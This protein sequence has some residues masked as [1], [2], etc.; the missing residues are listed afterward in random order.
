MPFML[1]EADALKAKLGGIQVN[2]SSGSREIPVYFRNPENELQ[3]MTFPSIVMEYGSVTKADDREH[4]GVTTLP[5]I[6][7][8]YGPGPVASIDTL[9]GV[10]VEFSGGQDGKDFDPSLSPFKVKDWPV[11][12][13]IDFTITIYSRFQTELM[14]IIAELAMV[15]RIPSRFGFLE[16]PQDGTTRTLDLMAGPEIVAERDAGNRRVF[17]AVYSVRVTSELNLFGVELI[18]SL[19][20]RVDI[21]L[22]VLT[23]I[24]S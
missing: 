9:S 14:P 10:D 3:D 11:P 15:D 22:R 5:Y 20:N 23:A 19:I 24:P 21:D 16:I 17:R 1:N 13:N 2:D 4:R 18:T 6:P 8:G 7:E 12:Y